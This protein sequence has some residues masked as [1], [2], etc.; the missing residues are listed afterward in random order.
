MLIRMD[1]SRGERVLLKGIALAL[2]SAVWHWV[3]RGWWVWL[4]IHAYPCG[5]CVPHAE[6]AMFEGGVVWWARSNSVRQVMQR[7]VRDLSGW[8]QFLA[9]CAGQEKHLTRAGG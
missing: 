7:G 9:A 5:D 2:A 3:H 8:S 1:G 6:H 4:R